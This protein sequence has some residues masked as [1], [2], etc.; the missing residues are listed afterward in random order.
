MPCLSKGFLNLGTISIL[1]QIIFAV[2]AV[3]CI[4]DIWQHLGPL[5]THYRLSPPRVVT[6]RMSPDATE[7]PPKVAPSPLVEDHLG[8]AH[9]LVLLFFLPRGVMILHLFFHGFGV[10]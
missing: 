8:L 4:I 6:T 1:D 2:E 9:T 5:P 10:P 7:H 3:P